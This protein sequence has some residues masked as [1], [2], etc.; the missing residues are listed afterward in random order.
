MNFFVTI[1]LL[2]VTVSAM[3][4]DH[5][6]GLWDFPALDGQKHFRDFH[7]HNEDT[8]EFVKLKYT[9]ET[10]G[11]KI[12]HLKGGIGLDGLYC[13]TTAHEVVAS[14]ETKEDADRFYNEAV[15]S[16][17]VSSF[18]P[19]QC[20]KGHVLMRIKKAQKFGPRMV[21]VVGNKMHNFL[22]LFKTL[23]MQFHT[24]MGPHGD[25]VTTNHWGNETGHHANAQATGGT[26]TGPE[27][28]DN[29]ELYQRRIFE[30]TTSEI[31]ATRKVEY[32]TKI[33]N[34]ALNNDLAKMDEAARDAFF[35]QQTASPEDVNSYSTDETAAHHRAMAALGWSIEWDG[36]I[37]TGIKFDYRLTPGP[38][39]WN[40][41]MSIPGTMK[42]TLEQELMKRSFSKGGV[43]VSH[44]STLTSLPT[45]HFII[46]WGSWRLWGA[47]LWYEN[48][49]V[50]NSKTTLEFDGVASM[51]WTNK[52][53][54]LD[55]PGI[56][57]PLVF[58]TISL[59]PE[60]SIYF[61]PT[62][63]FD[64]GV[65]YK[66]VRE[67]KYV[68]YQAQGFKYY[69]DWGGLQR[70]NSKSDPVSVPANYDPVIYSCTVDKV[71]PAAAYKR[72][73]VY[74]CAK[75]C[76]KDS[77]CT[78]FRI[79]NGICEPFSS[80]AESSIR[81][82][83][84]EYYK[85]AYTLVNQ[86]SLQVGDAE[87][88]IDFPFVVSMAL[89]VTLGGACGAGIDF[90][91]AN[92]D[93]SIG[94]YFTLKRMPLVNPQ[95]A[96]V[97]QKMA[98][99]YLAQISVN[100]DGNHVWAVDYADNIW[101]SPNGGPWQSI[102]GGLKQIAVS[103]N[104]NH[105]WGVTRT[106]LVY[107]RAGPKGSWVQQQASL[108]QIAVN[109]D[110]TK[111]IG[112]AWDGSIWT[113]TGP[114][115]KF[116]S[117]KGQLKQVDISG[118]GKHV[119]GVSKMGEV[120]YLPP[121]A[122]DWIHYDGTF[123]SI[124]VN[125]DG[126]IV[127]G[128]TKSFGIRVRKGP[129][130]VWATF[131]GSVKQLDV[132]GDGKLVF[133]VN[134]RYEAW[135][136]VIPP[137]QPAY[138]DY[139]FDMGIRATLSFSVIF[140]LQFK[141]DW[142]FIHWEWTLWRAEL[143]KYTVYNY[144]V[145]IQRF[146]IRTIIN[147]NVF[148]SM[149]EEFDGNQLHLVSNIADTLMEPFGPTPI[150]LKSDPIM[151]TIPLLPMATVT[152][153]PDLPFSSSG[154]TLADIL[155]DNEAN[156]RDFF[157]KR[158]FSSST[159]WTGTCDSEVFMYHVTVQYVNNRRFVIQYDVSHGQSTCTLNA[160]Y[161]ASGMIYGRLTLKH[162]PDPTFDRDT[163]WMQNVSQELKL[164]PTRN[165][166]FIVF[167]RWGFCP[168]VSLRQSSS[169]IMMK[170]GQ[171]LIEGQALLSGKTKLEVRVDGNVNLFLTDMD[172]VLWSSNTPAIMEK[173]TRLTSTLT[174][175][176]DGKL[177]LDQ[178]Y[179]GDLQPFLLR[180]LGGGPT[181]TFLQILD[182]D[183]RLYSSTLGTPNDVTYSMTG[184]DTCSNLV[185]DKEYPKWHRAGSVLYQ[186]EV[187]Y[188]NTALY[189]KEC[190]FEH[191][192]GRA[193]IVSWSTLETLWSTTAINASTAPDTAVFTLLWNG[194]LALIGKN[195]EIRWQS[196]TAGSGATFA[197]LQGCQLS[198][199]KASGDSVWSTGTGD[200]AVSLRANKRRGVT[201]FGNEFP[202]N[203]KTSSLKRSHMEMG[204]ALL[205]GQ[206]ILSRNAIL[207]HQPGKVVLYC[208]YGPSCV[209]PL[210]GIIPTGTT[211][212]DGR[213]K[214]LAPRETVETTAFA[215]S[216]DGN[217]GLF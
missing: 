124:S 53:Y 107:Y 92:I 86:D 40:L 77:R 42:L 57:F 121:G 157:N 195:G 41:P 159:G 2:T 216:H 168:D 112:V 142:K 74:D 209:T 182:C 206:S 28:Y 148:F 119:W 96:T 51:T 46:I 162:L 94:L 109:N 155:N 101:Y 191:E 67:R 203:P 210:W 178:R 25:P 207:I 87:L 10:H 213:T 9:V 21:R 15:S 24:N 71:I 125:G 14:F 49:W 146:T 205:P 82:A 145:L 93:F 3:S 129:S 181:S 23:E 202:E 36:P 167:N 43:T 11:D 143:V 138:R 193:H 171:S 163:C 134:D 52:I 177:V 211:E 183:A 161:N 80:C 186:G 17:V 73:N 204:D 100:A 6:P 50:L 151:N 127:Y 37:P 95:S 47:E 33:A 90:G 153:S 214:T 68:G 98:S 123:D 20:K 165:D 166:G 176:N 185:L 29:P 199:H 69:R 30:K 133:G 18:P 149:L 39:K 115:G 154:I 201:T 79:N 174:F 5:V 19:I 26:N 135:R 105:I 156:L 189:S 188:E 170:R 164:V 192:M 132:S 70:I 89:H 72:L 122:T 66:T 99:T 61:N 152:L 56:T 85:K 59:C 197:K 8:G 212:K 76:D 103:G 48:T 198:L 63:T 55:F 54:E 108:N 1:A 187:M 118:D 106:N 141:F 81:L 102:P 84:K 150:V 175:T 172:V 7:Y 215:F 104:G 88:R 128:V 45:F 131:A 16:D 64:S 110:G 111:V 140:Q 75:E 169:M 91:G 139:V 12:L 35:K 184:R 44:V 180:T 208:R 13:H 117:M 136:Q 97:W 190:I 58:L 217:L 126:T 179:D 60:F 144:E 78:Y 65:H 32:E 38:Y 173:S 31:E 113:T 196:N 147:S 137:Y 62:I 200:G 116:S 34:N 120:Y 83:G 158:N 160:L 194:N 114:N 22:E 4:I 130:G 27:Y